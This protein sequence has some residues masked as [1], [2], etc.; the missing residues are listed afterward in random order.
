MKKRIIPILFVFLMF[1][2]STA[3]AA[4][5]RAAQVVPSISF[6]GATATCSVIIVSDNLSD[7]VEAVIKFWEGSRCVETWEKSSVGY[8]VFSG[9]APATKGRTYQLTVDV[10]LD[11]KPLQRFSIDGT[12]K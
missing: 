5:P 4:T 1:F 9:E 3:Y 6:E 12:Y 8:L 10:T 2:S 7:D 11:G